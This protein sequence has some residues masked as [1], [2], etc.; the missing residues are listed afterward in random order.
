MRRLPV[1]LVLDVS[2]SMMGEAIEAVKTGVQSLVTALRQDPHALETAYLSVITFSDRAR[3]IVPLTELAL[4]N[5][6][7]ISALGRTALGEALE[8]LA[9]C[10]NQEVVKS[11]ATIKGDWKPMVFLMT[12]GRPTDDWELGLRF[13]Q[14]ANAGLVVACA[15]GKKADTNVLKRITNTVVQLDTADA[16]SIAAYFEWVS[17]SISTSSIRLEKGDEPDSKGGPEELPPPP[18]E[19][20]LVI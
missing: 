18:P 14:A 11:T 17:A 5:P 19:I 2:G 4:F 9:I 6:P 20:N 7:N 10:I 13:F 15:A 3:Q 16:A 1:Y 12:D 8:Q